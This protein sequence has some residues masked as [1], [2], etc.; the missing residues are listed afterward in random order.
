MRALGLAPRED[1]VLRLLHL[2]RLLEKWNRVYNLSAIVAPQQVI[3]RHFLESL[4]VVA[5]LQGARILDVGT[6]A[7]FPGLPLALACPEK[8]FVLLDSGAKK[9]RFV[10]QSVIELGIGNVDV[11]HGRVEDFR[12]DAGFDTI[13]TRAFSSLETIWAMTRRLLAP[14]GVL[15]AMKGR[16][17][18]DELRQLTG[19]VRAEVV[20]LPVPG[21]PATGHLVRLTPVAPDQRG[22]G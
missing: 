22:G 8:R 20:A 4:A 2:Q 9:T 1:L 3:G 12:A 21:A 14:G 16:R 13:V 5:H 7:G 11:V 19:E 17:F 15:L 10:R 18:E 6:G